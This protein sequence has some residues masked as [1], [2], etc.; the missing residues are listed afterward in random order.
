MYQGMQQREGFGLGDD[1]QTDALQG[2]IRPVCGV[3][4][5]IPLTDN[6]GN[7]AMLNLQPAVGGNAGQIIEFEGEVAPPNRAGHQLLGRACATD[8]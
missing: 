7:T 1:Y 2:P 4:L 3:G 5:R 6:S 8:Q